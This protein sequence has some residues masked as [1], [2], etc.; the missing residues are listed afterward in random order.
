MRWRIYYDD[1]TRCDSHTCEPEDAPG[2]GVLVI[3]QRDSKYNRSILS[4]H[5]YYYWHHSDALWYPADLTGILDQFSNF[6][7]DVSALK[8]GRM[9]STVRFDK[10]LARATNDPDFPP[11]SAGLNTLER[12]AD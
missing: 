11:A 4:R 5:N 6:P 3:I 1:G 10:I 2:W 8:V 9:V 12:G 7:R